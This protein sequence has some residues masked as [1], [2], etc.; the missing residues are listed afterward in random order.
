MQIFLWKQ[1]K[2][3]LQKFEEF[4]FKFNAGID[5]FEI[6]AGR[7]EP[8][9]HILR[10][11]LQRGKHCH[12][13]FNKISSAHRYTIGGS[14]FGSLSSAV[15]ADKFFKIIFRKGRCGGNWPEMVHRE[16]LVFI[17]YNFDLFDEPTA[18]EDLILE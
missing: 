1:V 10:K 15:T 5:L 6:V 9:K 8:C 16:S 12:N 14:R 13:S 4:T 11:H 2:N 3:I 17:F 7:G 18:I